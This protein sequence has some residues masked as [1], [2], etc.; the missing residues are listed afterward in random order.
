MASLGVA[1]LAGPRVTQATWAAQGVSGLLGESDAA[2]APAQQFDP[3]VSSVWA[4]VEALQSSDAQQSSY[5]A[6]LGAVAV[7][8]SVASASRRR[9]H[10]RSAAT[11]C[12]GLPDESSGAGT[13]ELAG[14]ASRA[15]LLRSLSRASAAGLLVGLA[16]PEESRAAPA[17]RLPDLKGRYAVVTGASRGIGKGTAIGLGEAGATVFVTGRDQTRT[18]ET[19]DLVTKAGGRGVAIV[20]DHEDDA[21]VAAAFK[22]ISEETGGR[23]DLLV[24]NAFK[25]PSANPEVDKALSSGAKFYE[26][27]LSVW[28]DM[29]RV[30]LRSHYVASYY[31]APMLVASARAQDALPADKRLR[32]MICTTS[33]FG[34]VSYLFTAAYGA[35]KAAS[36]RLARDLQ[37]ELGPL[38]VDCLSVWPGL[39][40]TEKVKDLLKK[41]PSRINRITGG[42][43]PERV[44]ES[45][46]LTGRVVSR[47]L[48]EEDLRKPPYV[49]APGLTGGVCIIAEAAKDLG[50][51]DGGAPGSVA[52]ELYGAVR[53]PAPSIR[54]LGFLGPGPIQTALP[55]SA[56]WLAAPGGPLANDSVR[57][58]LEFMAQGPPPN[59]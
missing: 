48:A 35:G 53:A 18:Q 37:V 50:I 2:A 26:M 40:L 5:L 57:F 15:G 16:S 25:D 58:P 52:S 56:K 45:P 17:N 7:G 22:R 31:A 36:D 55:E 43:D 6:V 49:T 3:P 21:Q 51:R 42:Q 13:E 23:L 14:A 28:D 24:N 32:P 9:L 33:S 46:L 12:R 44:G 29:H 41:D 19:A 38:G 4:E 47:L 54:S 11:S 8:G 34:A 10:R 39:V 20:C 59:P 30:G 27:P 1:F